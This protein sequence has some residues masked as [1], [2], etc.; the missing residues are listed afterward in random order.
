MLQFNPQVCR[1]I[2]FYT[3]RPVNTERGRLAGYESSLLMTRNCVPT[4]FSAQYAT[5]NM[6]VSTSRQ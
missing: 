6:D 3:I 1:F 5:N 4:M 2:P